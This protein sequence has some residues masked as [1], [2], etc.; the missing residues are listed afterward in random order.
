MITLPDSN[1][2]VPI[3][4]LQV[5]LS[6]RLHYSLKSNPPWHEDVTR[7]FQHVIVMLGTT[8]MVST[9]LVHLMGGNDVSCSR[10]L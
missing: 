1:F 8:V 7:A 9:Q 2:E 3:H 4:I 10:C 6:S 5:N